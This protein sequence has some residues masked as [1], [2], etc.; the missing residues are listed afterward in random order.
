[1]S[2]E[3]KCRYRVERAPQFRGM[4]HFAVHW[5]LRDTESVIVPI[6]RTRRRIDSLLYFCTVPISRK[7]NI[8]KLPLRLSYVS[9]HEFHSPV[10]ANRH[11]N[12]ILSSTIRAR[13]TG[14]DV[15]YREKVIAAAC[16]ALQ[17][18]IQHYHVYHHYHI[19]L[20]TITRM[21]RIYAISISVQC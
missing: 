18:R 4:V 7:K 5:L 15:A 17:K 10:T 13:R 8:A 11:V 1:M 2:Q 12:R 14:S 19:K 9:F 16:V 20:C 21:E 3:V 6:S